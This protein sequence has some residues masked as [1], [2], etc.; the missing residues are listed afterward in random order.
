[1]MSMRMRFFFLS[2]ALLALAGCGPRGTS[3]VGVDAAAA[4]DDPAKLALEAKVTG[5]IESTRLPS[6]IETGIVTLGDGERV[7]FWFKSRHFD[8]DFGCTRFQYS[9][10]SVDYLEGFFCCEVD[11]PGVRLADRKALREFIAANDGKEP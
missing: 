6:N 2:V 7:K 8:T 10:G 4:K 11:L 5:Y 3:K 1:M 9:D